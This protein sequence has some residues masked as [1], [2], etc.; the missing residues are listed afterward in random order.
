MEQ[1]RSYLLSLIC[2]ALLCSIVT[3][4]CARSGK[5][6]TVIRFLT[7]IYMSVAL[8]QPLLAL[9]PASFVIS[10]PYVDSASNLVDEAQQ[11]ATTE[12]RRVIKEKT[13]AYIL[14]KACAMGAQIKADITLCKDDPPLPEAVCISGS[15][16]PY[17]KQQLSAYMAEQ[18][19]IPK[20]A[21]Q[22]MQ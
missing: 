14:D 8:C 18:L 6:T 3:A 12:L 11:T 20:E 17:A 15:I 2:A 16:A 1:I 10:L 4:L 9:T 13:Q 21:Q 5:L 22:W 19:G 7:G